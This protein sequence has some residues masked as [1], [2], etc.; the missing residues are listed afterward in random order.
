[1]ALTGILFDK[2]GTLIDFEASWSRVYRELALD[3]ARGDAVR[4]EAM[5][6]AGGL[7]RATGRIRAGTV[8][9]AG[10]TAD[11]ARL[12]FPELAGEAFATL[13]VDIDAIFHRNGI[14]CSVPM[15]GLAATL[16]R[17]AGMGFVMGV[18]T[19]DGTAAAKAALQMLG[20]APR[21][22]HIFGYDSV[23]R[24]KPGPDMV[25]AFAAATG[26]TPPEIL[27]IGDNHH[28]LAMARAA[29]AGAAIGVLSG[30]GEEADPAPLADAIL[31]DINA[32][33]GWLAH[34]NM[35]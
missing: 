35:K 28:D 29:G 19:S 32:L 24:P 6:I 1:M 2:D 31:P 27:V 4:A 25:F 3:L 5:M 21:L 17:L 8:L 30:T 13:V 10:T 16:D 9:A 12:W 18:A 7:D 23:A 34:Q 26:L 14:A 15:P 11:I 22:P 20:V 33:P